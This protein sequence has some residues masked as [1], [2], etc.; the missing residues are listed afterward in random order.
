MHAS[1]V[2]ASV[3]TSVS[4]AS[5]LCV[6]VCVR[7]CAR[8]CVYTT[9]SYLSHVCVRACVCACASVR[10]CARVCV[11]VCVCVRACVRAC[12]RV[13]VCAGVVHKSELL[14]VLAVSSGTPEMNSL[15][16][17]ERKVG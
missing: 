8:A 2:R 12:V 16:A 15:A 9:V 11:R 1:G 4:S 5:H 6:C 13:C 7:A 14:N 10:V 17:S 3:F